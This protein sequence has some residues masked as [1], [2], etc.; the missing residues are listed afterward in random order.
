MAASEILGSQVFLND[1]ILIEE[2]RGLKSLLY[3]KN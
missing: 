2:L 3:W 1:Y